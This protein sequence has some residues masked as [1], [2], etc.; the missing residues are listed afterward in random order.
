[1]NEQQLY[2][3]PMAPITQFNDTLFVPKGIRYSWFRDNEHIATTNKNYWIP[4]Q[5][6]TYK[7]Q[8]RFREYTTFSCEIQI[9]L[10]DLNEQNQPNEYKIS[11]NP[12]TGDQLNILCDSKIEELIITSSNGAILYKAY[13]LYCN[14]PI[15]LEEIYTPGIYYV[16]ITSGGQKYLLNFMYMG[17]N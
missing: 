8:I 9:V 6:G 1:M 16:T 2:D 13:D 3:K 15:K 17:S 11:P 5:S 7:A 14:D 10:T 12:V 4:D